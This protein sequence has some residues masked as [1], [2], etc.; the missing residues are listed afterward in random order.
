MHSDCVR[1]V[2][3]VAFFGWQCHHFT[4]KTHD[5]ACAR[6]RQGYAAHKIDALG[7]PRPQLKQVSR[8]TN[9]N[10]LAFAFL[11]V[12]EMQIASLFINDFPVTR[13]SVE[14]R[15]VLVLSEWLNRLRLQIKRKKI[16]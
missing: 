14:H 5:D 15:K 3:G 8:Y 9:R 13:R 6:R 4:P 12:E 1:Q 2:A 7:V 10:F 11:G 16:K